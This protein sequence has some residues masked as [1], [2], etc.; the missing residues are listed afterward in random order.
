MRPTN[1]PVAMFKILI[2]YL[3]KFKFSVVY[4]DRQ[5]MREVEIKNF[6][7]AEILF[8]QFTTAYK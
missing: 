1:Q 7:R 5:G 6:T 2:S 8:E 4:F 3:N